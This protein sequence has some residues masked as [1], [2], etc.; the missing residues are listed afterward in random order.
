MIVTLNEL[1]KTRRVEGPRA[2]SRGLTPGVQVYRS[3]GC[4]W[5]TSKP[6]SSSPLTL[7]P[8]FFLSFSILTFLSYLH[9]HEHIYQCLQPFRKDR[10]AE[11]YQHKRLN[12][13]RPQPRELQE[14]RQ[15]GRAQGVA[16][17][18]VETPAMMTM[19]VGPARQLTGDGAQAQVKACVGSPD[20]DLELLLCERYG[21]IRRAQIYFFESYRLLVW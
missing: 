20:S 9:P 18:S 6:H 1:W 4:Q 12:K 11:R 21:S 10:W 7:S 19:T 2:W 14:C 15:H 16:D 3:T 5:P 17:H 13:V 8:L